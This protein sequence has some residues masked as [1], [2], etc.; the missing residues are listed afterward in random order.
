M[1]TVQMH[2]LIRDKEVSINWFYG[3]NRQAVKPLSSLGG[4]G[5]EV[6]VCRSQIGLKKIID[7]VII[8]KLNH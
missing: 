5:W 8:T 2:A 7:N 6:G 4:V 3:F 1:A